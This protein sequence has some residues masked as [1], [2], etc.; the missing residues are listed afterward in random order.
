VIVAVLTPLAGLL[1]QGS[2]PDDRFVSV[3]LP[4][5]LLHG[6]MLIAF[7]RPDVTG[8][9]AAGKHTL[10]V[11]L[12]PGKSGRLHAA[13]VAGAFVALAFAIQ[14]GP[15]GWSEAGWAL[16]LAPLGLFQARWFTRAP[17]AMLATAALGLF[18][19]SGLALLVGLA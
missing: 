8:D 3:V 9:T 13:L 2:A 11:R 14:P 19:G 12:G 18:G 7:E 16:A 1:V 15:L 4:L 5:L 10:S 6:A 17:D